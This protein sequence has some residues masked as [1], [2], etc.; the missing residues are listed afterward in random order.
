MRRRGWSWWQ[1]DSQPACLPG[2]WIDWPTACLPGGWIDW[3]TA[4]LP[5]WRVARLTA[6]LDTWRVAR[7]IPV[8][9]EPSFTWNGGRVLIQFK[10]TIQT[11]PKTKKRQTSLEKHSL[12][13]I[14]KWKG[15]EEKLFLLQNYKYKKSENVK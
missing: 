14:K 5:T 10:S 12:E 11:K 2:G 1:T 8:R 13:N 9:L 15:V 7:L 6:S 3:P 4:C